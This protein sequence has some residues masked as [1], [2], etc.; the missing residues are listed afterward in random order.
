MNDRAAVVI[1]GN[2]C[3][4]LVHRRKKGRDYYVVPGGGV[5][6]SETPHEAGVREAKEETNLTV[7]LGRKLCTLDNDGR[8]EHYFLAASYHGELRING[9]ERG[10]QAPNNLYEPEWV[11]VG[12]LQTINLQPSTI[13]HVLADCLSTDP[14]RQNYASSAKI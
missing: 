12:R 13:R 14:V 6:P 11:G 2:N 3:V 7:K 1:V 10:R 4:L 9:P 8:L 5:E